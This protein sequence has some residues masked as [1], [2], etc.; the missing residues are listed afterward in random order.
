MSIILSHHL[1]PEYKILFCKGAD[2]VID[3]LLLKK[4]KDLDKD[5]L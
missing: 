4:Y 2:N 1:L 5:S 3:R